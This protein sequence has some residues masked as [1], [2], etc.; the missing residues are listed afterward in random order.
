[1]ATSQTH[2]SSVAEAGQGERHGLY[3][4]ALA[5]LLGTL[6]VAFGIIVYAKAVLLAGSTAGLALLL[7]YVTGIPFWIIFSAVNLPFYALAFIRLGWQFALRT[8]IAVSL[9][10][11]FAS[12]MTNWVSFSELDPLFAAVIGGCLS[13][14]GLLVLFRHRTGLGGINILAIYLQ[15]KF[16]LR[17]G[18]FQLA[19][20]LSILG[21]AFFVLPPGNL[22]LSVLGAV[23]VNMILAINHR[24]GRYAGLT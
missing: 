13:G 4:D 10:S 12:L 5:I 18:Y 7:Q 16:G 9:V 2:P 3:E 15:E 19:V 1:M 14:S 8:F 11:L 22:A 24:P 6:F 17:A 21:A 23:I 20:D